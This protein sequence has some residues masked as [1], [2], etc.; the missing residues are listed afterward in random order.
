MVEITT[1]S[2]DMYEAFYGLDQLKTPAEFGQFALTLAGWVPQLA[3]EELGEMGQT[4]K[5]QL[6]S[7]LAISLVAD[8]ALLE[9]TSAKELR[10]FF[11]TPVILE[12]VQPATE[13]GRN[14]LSAQRAAKETALETRNIWLETYRLMATLLV[15]L[16]DQRRQK[17]TELR[18]TQ[19]ARQQLSEVKTEGNVP[20]KTW[21]SKGRD[22]FRSKEKS[23]EQDVERLKSLQ[24]RITGS[25][26]ILGSKGSI[27]AST[28]NTQT[29]L[30]ELDPFRAVP[31]A[32]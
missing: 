26:A 21:K 25:I 31:M 19:K 32:A 8:E 13:L 6:E 9:A 1:R 29:E 12:A 15:A 23:Q 17:E 28:A 10:Q 22:Q 11:G 16:E 24:R 4:V 3:E 20:V 18:Q 2:R 30:S 14:E 7:L 5:S 27:Y